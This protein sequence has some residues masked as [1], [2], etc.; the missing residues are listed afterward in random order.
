MLW[1]WLSLA[2]ALF[3][4]VDIALNKKALHKVSPATLNW[5]LYVL[6]LPVLLIL[7]LREDIPT[8][9][10]MFWISVFGS[11]ITFALGKNIIY[12]ALKNGLISKIIPLTSFTS[13]FTYI[14]ALMFLG[15]NLRFLPVLGLFLIVIGSYILNVDQAREDIFK[16][17]KLL[18]ASKSSLIFMLALILTSTTAIFDKEAVLTTN[19]KGPLFVLLIENIL[20]STFLT[21]YL[22]YKEKTTWVG[23]LK[24]SF[25]ILFANS[26]VYLM[27]AYLIFQAYSID[28]PVAL[29]LGIKRLQIFFALILGYFFLR[30]KPA[31]HAWIATIIIIFGVILIKID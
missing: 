31:K 22:F 1:F 8:I 14:L 15:E 29:V 10:S 16:P 9:N 13:I 26:Y 18:F 11:A 4:A 2:S 28:G 19:S 17:F 21:F 20:M 5:S 27:I 6:S 23:Q 7:A 25:G 30:D 3:G 24:G 12:D